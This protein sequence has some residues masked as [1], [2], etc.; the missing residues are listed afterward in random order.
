[1][2]DPDPAPAR[3][4]CQGGELAGHSFDLGGE[5]VIG[6]KEGHDIV[7]R[8]QGIAPDH[9]RVYVQEGEFFLEDLG[10][11]D[12]IRLDGS[13]LQGPA[14]LERLHVIELAEG[15]EFLFVREAESRKGQE[16]A[17]PS[18][19]GAATSSAG[20]PGAVG[21][22]PGAA[23]ATGEPD[24]PEG[25]EAGHTMVDQAGFGFLPEKFRPDA[26]GSGSEGEDE[27][28]APAEEKDE[29]EREA[30]PDDARGGAPPESGTVVDRQGFGALP[31]RFRPAEADA[32]QPAAGQPEADRAGPA[33]A[34]AD[35]QEPAGAGERAPAADEEAPETGEGDEAPG[36]GGSGGPAGGDP[37]ATV[38]SPG[39]GPE[40]PPRY[41]L[42]AAL[43][44]GGTRTFSLQPGENVIGRDPQCDVPVE[45]PEKWLSRRH[46]VLQVGDEGVELADLDSINGVFVEGR[47]IGQVAIEPGASFT[48]G[49]HLRFTLRQE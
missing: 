43:P 2:S 12:G 45:D 3:L 28:E 15:L 8:S 13:R 32:A 18:G 41:Q 48:L 36:G 27:P 16:D 14:R 24:G 19:E 47:K 10:S 31:E 29:A 46:A 6:S 23:P 21:G 40:A 1:M 4:V 26:A 33:P 38:V 5:T 37:G 35:E 34:E 39:A 17:P 30:G 42:E 11:P 20:G 44:R 7:L 9:A 49:P 22:E 25:P